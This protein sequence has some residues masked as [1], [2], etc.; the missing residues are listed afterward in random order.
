MNRYA[1]ARADGGAG[2]QAHGAMLLQRK[3]ECGNHS[4]G[5]GQ[6]SACA[7][8]AGAL[9]R[10]LTIGA[11]DDGW[12]QEAD[13]VADQV[14]AAKPVG[15][16]ASAPPRIQRAPAREPSDDGPDGREAAPDSVTRVL[17]GAGRPLE[18][19]LRRDMERR[20]RHDFSQV[21]V[22]TGTAA[23]RSAHEVGAQ[24]YTVG[25]DLVFGAQRYAPATPAGRHLL[26]H[27]LTHVVQQGGAPAHTLRAKP[28]KKG[29][30]AG[31]AGKTAKAP[32]PKV[33]QICGRDSKKIKDNFITKV[34]IDVGANT[35]TIEW[36]DPKKIPPGGTGPH[37]ISPGTGLC[38]KD[39]NDPATSQ[40][41]GSLCTPKGGTWKVSATGCALGGH[42]G[43]KNPTYFQ[44]AGV[45]IHSG[46]TGSPPRSHGCARTDETV[47][48]LIHDNV[49]VDKTDIAS[50]GTWTSA[51][52]YMKEATDTLSKRSDVC[53]GDKLKPKPAPKAKPK[54]KATPKGKGPAKK[55]DAPA[56]VPSTP[57]PKSKP[58]PVA[59][60]EGM[61]LEDEDALAMGDA[62]VAGEAPLGVL[63]DGPGP[64]NEPASSGAIGPI[65]LAD[66]DPRDDADGGA[67]EDGAGAES[68]LA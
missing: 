29:G 43:A 12:E 40:A 11:S 7:A 49:I 59:G 50:S 22:H 47:S 58:V 42:P 67:G 32:K 68:A 24:A 48:Q 65:P 8:K 38:C 63:P 57:T 21:R 61:P 46:N 16:V 30:N 33:P 27:E 13:R 31:K 3:C 62:D 56:D 51:N 6:C 45:A 39:C 25:R 5:G 36:D 64:D 10:K 37:A 44:R 4:P 17:N 20:F 19:G 41:S 55:V 14:L 52:C 35:L 66:L 28:E 53:D 23:E 60:A 34:N 15:G 2:P 18:A 1:P 9:Q 54:P 26:A